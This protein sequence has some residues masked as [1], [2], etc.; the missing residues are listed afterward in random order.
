MFQMARHVGKSGHLHARAPR[1]AAF[2]CLCEAGLRGSNA[3]DYRATAVA[4]ARLPRSRCVATDGP[5]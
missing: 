2:W 3:I 5:R 4:Q 1:L